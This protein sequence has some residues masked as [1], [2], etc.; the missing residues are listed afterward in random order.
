MRP[1]LPSQT[2]APLTYILQDPSRTFLFL[3]R[4]KMFRILKRNSNRSGP[5]R[6]LLIPVLFIC[7]PNE[8][9]MGDL[10]PDREHK[11][12]SRSCGSYFCAKWPP[13]QHVAEAPPPTLAPAPAPAA[14]PLP[15]Q[16]PDPDSTVTLIP[17]PEL[18]PGQPF[19]PVLNSNSEC[20]NDCSHRGGACPGFC[21][22]GGV[23]RD[24]GRYIDKMAP[25]CRDSHEKMPD[26][27]TH[28]CLWFQ[29]L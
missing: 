22:T 18:T 19:G 4:R 23:L 14:A 9:P 13:F 29:C 24:G 7:L 10:Y 6:M 27:F 8:I 25:C 28:H 21:G 11:M 17:E 26:G 1:R 16:L 5:E 2:H 20:W 15:A 12:A 3:K